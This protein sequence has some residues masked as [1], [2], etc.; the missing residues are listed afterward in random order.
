MLLH[1]T[2]RTR[3]PTLDRLAQYLI[4]AGTDQGQMGAGTGD[5]RM[6]ELAGQNRA[7]RVG[8]DE[9]RVGKFRALG[10][11]HGEGIE[12]L[13]RLEATRQ[14]LF[15]GV[16]AIASGK[17][18]TQRQF[19]SSTAGP[20][21]GDADVA[22]HQAE[23]SG[24]P[25]QGDHPE[26]DRPALPLEVDIEDIPI[27]KADDVSI[28]EDA[29]PDPIVQLPATLLRRAGFGLRPLG[30]RIALRDPDL[31]QIP[32]QQGHGTRRGGR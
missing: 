18:D 7:R 22:V 10:L 17:G 13:D 3:H 27:D 16:A 29:M 20:D 15:D 28:A 24:D 2:A 25:L 1:Q 21:K 14:D 12:G 6:E 4:V 32:I 19:V 30:R 11:V 8:Q 26:L 9:D 5:A 31:A 23:P